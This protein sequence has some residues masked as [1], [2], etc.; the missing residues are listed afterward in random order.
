M[1]LFLHKKALQSQGFFYGEYYSI[2]LDFL[3]ALIIAG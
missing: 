1:Y 2:S 3:A